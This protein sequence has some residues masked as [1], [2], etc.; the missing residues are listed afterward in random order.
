M[1]LI[2]FKDEKHPERIINAVD[3]NDGTALPIAGSV[4][5]AIEPMD[6]P[7]PFTPENLIA[8]LNPTAILAIGRNYEAHATEQGKKPPERPMLFMK[9]ISATT[10]PFDDIIIPKCCQ[11]IDQ[12][13]FEGELAIVIGK[14]A[15]DVTAENAF[16]YILGFTVANDVSARWWQ[17][18][19]G[20]GQFCRGKSFDTFCPLGP[21]VITTDEIADP[22]S[23]NIEAKLN[24]ETMQASNTRHMIFSVAQL[25]AF[26]SQGTTLVPG[27]VILTGTPSGVGFARKPPVFLH[28]GDVVEVTVEKIGTLRNRVVAA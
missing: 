6:E 17:K 27:T 9:N 22:Q 4:F 20:G 14:P 5:N 7:I 15:R 28:D 3:C 23:L 12:T 26:L 24:G 11:K 18:E 25:V 21:A 8:P 1:K 2:R 16:D 19:A 13:D 10:G